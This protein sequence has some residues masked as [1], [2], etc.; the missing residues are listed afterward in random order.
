M[1][2]LRPSQRQ[3]QQHP[4]LLGEAHQVPI[5]LAVETQL[6]RSEGFDAVG[7]GLCGIAG[8]VDGIV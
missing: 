3:H 8:T 6:G 5:D 2:I 4:G 1:R 7:V